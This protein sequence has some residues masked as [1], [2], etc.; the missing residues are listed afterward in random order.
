[1]QPHASAASQQAVPLYKRG[2]SHFDP[3]DRDR[4]RSFFQDGR[5]HLAVDGARARARVEDAQRSYGV[6]LDW[7]RVAAKRALHVFCECRR[8]AEGRTCEHIWAALLALY[9]T[10]PE[11]RPPG[12]DRVGLRK[13]RV[14]RW[15]DLGVAVAANADPEHLS[16]RAPSQDRS[17]QRAQ[18][19]IRSRRPSG[20]H[21]DHRSAGASWRTQL[22][23]LRDRIERFPDN[24]REPD[25]AD[26]RL[27][28]LVN[29]EAS[30][31]D[32]SLVLDVFEARFGASGNGSEDLA[33][34]RRASADSA[35]L[36]QLLRLTGSP[37]EPS[38]PV[39]VVTALPVEP[40]ARKGRQG[41]RR[42]VQ[43]PAD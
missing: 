10:G 14:S 21:A 15:K 24:A 20:P 17:G 16:T 36:E 33:E 4:G 5:V 9:E 42:R 39:T 26:R 2:L 25:G 7:S 41:Q 37:E 27:C 11:N 23:S 1:M 38:E 22:D 29:T 35:D 6:G 8:F 31:E 18:R 28:L 43:K 32:G 3:S 40:P 30:A 34:L 19:P 12:K 13:D